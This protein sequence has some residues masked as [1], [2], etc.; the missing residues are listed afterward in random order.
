MAR[1]VRSRDAEAEPVR[2]MPVAWRWRFAA[3]IGLTALLLVAALVLVW[4]EYRERDQQVAAQAALVVD[5]VE[6]QLRER[7]SLLA[8]HL[9]VVARQQLP[10]NSQG[11]DAP[12]DAHL[13]THGIVELSVERSDAGST[14]TRDTMDVAGL[15]LLPPEL[16]ASTL[17]MV[18]R[19]TP[20]VR[21]NAQIASER[22]A[23]VVQ[24]LSLSDQTI[25]ALVHEA[26]QRMYMRSVG[27]ATFIG[28]DL[29]GTA[30]FAPEHRGRRSGSY[31]GPSVIDG[32]HY[33]FV[34]QR[35]E[36]TPLIAVVA[37]PREQIAAQAAGF[38]AA[39]LLAALALGAMWLWLLRAFGAA[40]GKQA[41]LLRQLEQAQ[42]L[43]VLGTW[44]WR[45]D[46]HIV[47]WGGVSARIYGFPADTKAAP[48]NDIM[49][50]IHADDLKRVGD[51]MELARQGADTA[52]PD[53]IEHRVVRDD[54]S[55]RWVEARVETDDQPD[56]R[57]L[58][59]VQQDITELAQAR[60]RLRRAEQQYRFL[61]EHNPVP[62][63]VFD[64]DSLR[65]LAVNEA[66]LRQYGYGRDELLGMTVLDIRPEAERPAVVEAV[67]SPAD[68]RPQGAVWTHLCRDGSERRVVIHSNDIDFEG[69]PACLAAAQDVTERELNEQRFRLV[70]RATSDAIFDYNIDR[71]HL[72]WSESFY[73]TFDLD[74]AQVA[75]TL[76]AWEA[77]VH[78]DDL[79]RI[80]ASRAHAIDDPKADFWE[81]EYRFRRGDGRFVDVVDR[82]Y[83]V[84]ARDG[85]ATRMV[86][87]VL[88]V[89]EKH[90]H[91]ADLRLLSRAME[92]V[93]SG[94]VIADA[95]DPEMP[96]VYVNRAFEAMTGY[97]AAESLGRNCRFLQGSDHDQPELQQVRHALEE[98]REVR[99][100]LRNYRK[101]G[102]LFWNELILAPVQL[103]D[104]R[105]TH[106]VG[107]QSDVS[108]RRHQEQ[109]LAHR[110]THD[111][112]TGLPNR[113]LL[114]DRL[115]Q[116]I[117]NAGR[118]GR[119]AG[120]VF[121]DLDDFKL[122]NDNLN[123]AAGDEALCVV[124][125]RLRTLVRDTDTVGRFG[126]DE[127]VIVLTE[128]T[129][130]DG[131][132]QVISRITAALSTP[133]LIGGI[134]HTI[135]PSIGWCRY[136]EGGLD[137]DTLLK[138]ADMAM[139]QAKRQGRNRVVA[140]D[141][142][143][144]AQLSKRLQ[145]VAQLREALRREEFV[146]VF[147]PMFDS[148]GRPVALEALV[149][150]QHPQRG[151]LP[152]SEFIPVCEEAGLI[153]EL[154]RRTLR[155][156]A[157]HH[158]L[159]VAAGYPEVRLSVNVSPLQFGYALEED[160][161]AVV[162]EFSL[163]PGILELELTESVILEHPGRAIQA[164]Q[165]ISAL[166]VCLSID[167]FGTGYSSLAYLRRL[168]IDRL[169]IDRSF[170]EDLPKDR[171]AASIC[172]AII[173]LAHSL[174]L[175]TVAEGVET[176]AQLRWLH[177]RGCD[178]LQGF[179]LARPMP[180]EPLLELLAAPPVL[181][182]DP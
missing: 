155:E 16:G 67:R 127:F 34:Y 20:G 114:M 150:W 51:W 12:P 100:V 68:Q 125:A 37:T 169:K 5:G 99:V 32:E 69:R 2:G 97:T 75:S 9:A 11:A 45:L 116:A 63:W 135:T 131:V 176:K 55:V 17:G 61:F 65:Y 156:A 175:K 59:G 88:D 94:V 3:G 129:D 89:S 49:R 26:S 173:S 119:Q 107:I 142:E 151:L 14:V 108:H 96:L 52:W 159:L 158:A 40:H 85:R 27:N 120:V 174:S 66:M 149:R 118:Y 166:G 90:Q 164:M 171:E 172:D 152:P 132:G 72:W 104:G 103:A 78:P 122:V 18:W 147:Q 153:I 181:P 161:A 48:L 64:P 35:I 25:V 92:A 160:I 1:G 136:P 182:I 168:P 54:G 180:F 126:G 106:F 24:G 146:L 84:R 98:G 179:L 62:M 13:R 87:G 76:E 21:V 47:E 91:E 140:Y 143:F 112:L 137:A 79:Q 15:Q 77:R 38:A 121:I 165:R 109:E 128:Q 80:S 44:R 4:R 139:Y 82:G 33:Q 56:G 31:H 111:Q 170:V 101:D 74:P 28:R 42:R 113:Q 29:R 133:M 83:F 70:A 43:A 138:H 86:G 41:R 10:D 144:D 71:G 8:D 130:E 162:A 81:D 57:A 123:H 46:S 36:G 117:H 124:A 23:Q 105:V 73:A 102:A 58:F 19:G 167:D 60:E 154:G 7:L 50:R 110:A 115:Q 178:E 6:R 157:R 148:T 95:S 39:L 93:D 134:E 22:M 177:G 163:P 141:P 145:L 30:L 53:I